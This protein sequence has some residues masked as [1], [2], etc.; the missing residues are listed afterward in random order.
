[1]ISSLVLAL[2][3]RVWHT[4]RML[5]RITIYT[6]KMPE[7]IAFY[8]RH[9][10][11]EPLEREGDRITE[12]RHPDGGASIMLHAAAKSQKI[13]QVLVK[14]IMDVPDVEAT[15]ARLISEGVKVGSIWDGGGY[16]FANMK[17]PS[18]NPVSISSRYLAVP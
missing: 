6:R 7:M 3:C 2:A 16:Q 15:R 12:L 14:L 5:G 13:G 4:L 1:M 17:D 11:F 9:F 18:G 10:G 8:G